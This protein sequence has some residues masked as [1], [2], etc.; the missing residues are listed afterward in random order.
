MLSSLFASRKHILDTHACCGLRLV[1]VTQDG[2]GNSKGIL[3]HNNCY[4]LS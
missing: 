2:I 1:R 4:F 3:S